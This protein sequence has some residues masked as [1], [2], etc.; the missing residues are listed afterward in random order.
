MRQFASIEFGQIYSC[1]V[2]KEHLRKET[3]MSK[4][5]SIKLSGRAFIAG[6]LA[7][8]TILSNSDPIAFPGSWIS[9][10]LLAAGLLS[11]QAGY[12]ETVSRSG[13]NILRMGAVGAVLWDIVIVSLIVMASSGIL[14]ATEAQGQRFW[15]V[16]F[17]GPAVPLLAL[18]L[19]GLNAFRSNP[20]SR[21]NGL[22]ILAGI[23]Y[24][25]VYFFLFVYLIS[26]NGVLPDQYWP[27]VK[28]TFAIQ[29]FA[30]FVLG[31]VLV[32]DAPQEMAT[33]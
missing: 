8:A 22:S 3:D 7:F 12:G 11:L 13:R 5:E 31:V 24:S 10:L 17:G 19:F 27:L 33:T 9:A 15:I 25:A 14:R 1:I 21:L 18:T 6:A 30:L 32:T 20:L 26:Y 4:S 2:F 23:W 28:F 29:F 16:G